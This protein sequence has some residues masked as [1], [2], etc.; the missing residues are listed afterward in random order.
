MT[1]VALQNIGEE[2]FLQLVDLDKEIFIVL[3]MYVI[4]NS[5]SVHKNQSHV[6]CST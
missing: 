4:R 5:H 1:K 6:A 2:V 3:K